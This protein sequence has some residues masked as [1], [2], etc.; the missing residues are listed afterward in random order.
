[1]IGAG[2]ATEEQVTAA[3]RQL[4]ELGDDPSVLFGMPRNVQV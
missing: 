2:V 3:I 1:M 4:P